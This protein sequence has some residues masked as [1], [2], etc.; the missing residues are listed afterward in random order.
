MFKW[1][2]LLP[3]S[4]DRLSSIEW[5]LWFAAYAFGI[6]A[7]VAGFVAYQI[8]NYRGRIERSAAEAERDRLKTQNEELSE[9]QK[10]ADEE[11]ARARKEAAEAKSKAAEVEAKQAPRRLDSERASALGRELRSAPRGSILIVSP[12]GD[13]EAI[14]YA[15]DFR[16]IF[17]SAGWTVGWQSVMA[18]GLGI[19]VHVVVRRT[20]ASDAKTAALLRGLEPAAPG[21]SHEVETRISEDA[22]LFIGSK[23]PR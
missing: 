8:S 5:W 23:S 1:T 22:E 7:P 4:P 6:L 21:F 15:L 10:R 16:G 12:A 14:A 9:A 17:E 3:P 20:P 19:G 2:S 11:V 18:A 13:H